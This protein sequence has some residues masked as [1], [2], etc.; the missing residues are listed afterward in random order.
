MIKFKQIK[1][2]PLKVD[3]IRLELLNGLRK[4]NSLAVK[5]F[6]ETTRTWN[7]DK[8]R[9]ET[10]ISLAGGAITAVI[11]PKGSALALNKWNWLDKGT[12]VRYATMTPNFIP[13]TSPRTLGT[14]AGAGGLAFVSTR[15][16]HE[17][18]EARGWSAIIMVKWTPVFAE[19]MQEY[20][21][22]GAKKSGHSI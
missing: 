19:I 12:A 2:K 14:T 4:F 11:A 3:A 1:P 15:V 13:K 5:D 6:N 17:G 8:P 10:S 16:P 21:N 7:G 20:M 22:K 9:W 18:I